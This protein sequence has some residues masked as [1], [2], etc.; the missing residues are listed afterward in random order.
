[1]AASSL[2]SLPS[3]FP[4][5]KST[6]RPPENSNSKPKPKLKPK[7]S[8][9]AG[10]HLSRPA[11]SSLGNRRAHPPLP[12]LR[13]DSLS[14]AAEEPREQEGKTATNPTVTLHAPSAPIPIPIPGRRKYT[15]PT[16]PLTARETKG[17]HFPFLAQSPAE[18]AH[19]KN[20]REYYHQHLAAA[21]ASASASAA[22]PAPSKDRPSS[23][24]VQPPQAQQAAQE[25][26]NI[27]DQ[28]LPLPR[29]NLA[30]PLS[31]LQPMNQNPHLPR[32]AGKNMHLTSLPRFHP[33]N[34]PSAESSPTATHRASRSSVQQRQ[35]SEASQQLHQ[36]QRDL[37][38]SATMSARSLLSPNLS[39]PSP[40]RLHPLGSPGP[41]T[42]LMLEGQD[43]YLMGGSATSSRSFTATE[44]RE[45]A[46]RLIREEHDRIKHPG[47]RSARH[48]PA[49][50][51][52]GGR[53]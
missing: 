27:H 11:Q 52:A 48:S 24:S 43:D 44:G 42:P 28:P 46:D 16:T 21:S 17:G 1:M 3:R 34:Y 50:S 31:P 33:A 14:V 38:A 30:M 32:R 18:P 19:S 51:P 23:S 25:A 36:Y 29:Y 13:I 12:P 39:K 35:G 6:V 53:G 49:V 2:P 26:S 15:G 45:L 20:G 7:A 8:N 5:S 37:V 10:S 47:I 4:S 41:V 22:A 40:P 9:D